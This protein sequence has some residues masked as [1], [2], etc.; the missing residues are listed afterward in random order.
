MKWYKR[1]PDAERL[2]WLKAKYG[3]DCCGEFPLPPYVRYFVYVIG[4]ENGPAKIGLCRDLGQRIRALQ[5]ACPFPIDLFWSA[6][7]ASRE[8]AREIEIAAFQRFPR[9]NGEW[10]AV[11]PASIISFLEA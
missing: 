4:Q 1:D 11:S 8:I 2:A 3:Q 10:L 6:S 9:S 5:T 7:V